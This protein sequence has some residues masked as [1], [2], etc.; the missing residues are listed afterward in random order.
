MPVNIPRLRWWFAAL[1]IAL[2]AVVTGFYFY[3]RYRLRAAVRQI[4]EKIGINVQQSTT[5]FTFSKSEGGRTIF[6]VHASQAVQY[7]QGGRA[8]LKDVH[9]IVYGRQANRYDQIYG[10][11]F[12]YDPTAET[13]SALGVVYIDLEGNAEGP[14]N[15]DQATPEELKNPIHLKTSGLV[16]SRKTGVAETKQPL[17]FSVPQANGTAV[18]A[19]YDSRAAT[20][21]LIS[22]IRVHATEPH[23][24][25][26]KAAHGLIAAGPERAVL[27]DV[28]VER[29]SGNLQTSRLTILL[30][31]DNTVERVL[32]SGNVTA[33]QS[34][35]TSMTASAPAADMLLGAHNDL[36]SATMSGGVLVNTTGVEN[37]EARAGKVLFNFGPHNAVASVRAID[38]VHMLQRP[39][40]SGSGRPVE[41]TSDAMDFS[42][43]NGRVLTEAVTSGPAQI[44]ILPSAGLSAAGRSD[45]NATKTIATAGNF[46]A[47]FQHNRLASLTG[48]PNAKIV[49]SAPGQ[50]DKT[51]SSDDVEVS[52]APTGAIAGL[53]QRGNFHFIEPAEGG[54]REA[55]ADV[56]NY[57]SGT[58]AAD[59]LKLSGS[60]RFVEGGM[61][62]TA[63]RIEIARTSGDAFANGHV[64][65]TYSELKPQPGGALL[66]SADPIHV[67]GSSMV[68]H[69]GNGTAIYQN[70]RLWQG[71]NVVEA[72]VLEFRRDPRQVNA[73]GDTA[74][75]VTT[76][77][78]EQ[79]K[80]GKSTPISVT[81]AKLTYT[82]QN[83]QARFEGGVTMK[84]ADTT[85]IA[86]RL[87]IYLKPTVA[88][89][90]LSRGD[91]GTPSQLEKAVAAGGVVIQTPT[92]RAT[93]ENLTYT[94]SEGK[95]VL[96][97][98]SPSIF[99]AE[100]GKISGDSLTFFQHDDR[101]LVESRNAPTI[102]RTRVAK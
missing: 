35:R 89:A 17:E 44:A 63:D 97:G 26:I 77:F 30:R 43:R 8:E 78:V 46:R 90:A 85:V 91:S 86:A 39:A 96:T 13:I 51:S 34:G 99:D 28:H 27:D 4:P 94:S 102:T 73:N 57:T 47:K 83:R 92:R 41:I 23:Q 22:N 16:F 53:V 24:A 2:L 70:A 49:I 10:T 59:M 72:P 3:S 67:T 33:H 11:N 74:H 21:T 50:P 9:I 36:R 37:D 48:S 75:Q 45:D 40:A 71:P 14:L 64:K 19:V 93:G 65:T 54:R 5:G 84:G 95:F 32:A 60:P 56:A 38:G 18:G 62:T 101:V 66:A 6:T 58:S 68:A 87:D 81:A 7:K 69:R 1:A 52:F 98:G 80:N 61:T 88:A 31:P 25:D 82:D 15:P 76:L 12:E 100:H 42:V 55:W 20:L 79:D 29:A